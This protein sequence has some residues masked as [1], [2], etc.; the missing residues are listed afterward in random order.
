[1][2]EEECLYEHEKDPKEDESNGYCSKGEECD[3][4]ACNFS[5]RS[6]VIKRLICTFQSN[7]NRLNCPYKHTVARKAFLEVGASNSKEK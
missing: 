5:E 2:D 3:D 4:Q 7:C 1:M 6:H